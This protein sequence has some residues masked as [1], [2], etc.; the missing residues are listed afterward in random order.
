MNSDYDEDG[1]H[2]N[3]RQRENPA[4][5]A[6]VEKVLLARKAAHEEATRLLET[7]QRLLR[8]TPYQGYDDTLYA[9]GVKGVES[10]LAALRNDAPFISHWTDTYVG[11]KAASELGDAIARNL[12]I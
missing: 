7:A 2:Y 11:N 3:E 1:Y 5:R 6:E 8:T 10:A 4:I 12:H 9:R